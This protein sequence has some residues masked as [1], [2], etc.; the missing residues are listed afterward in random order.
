MYKILEEFG[1]GFVFVIFF[2]KQH[3]L[4][5]VLINSNS[6]QSQAPVFGFNQGFKP[7]MLDKERV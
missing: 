1:L 7:G 6:T 4:P 5:S 2:F 3:T